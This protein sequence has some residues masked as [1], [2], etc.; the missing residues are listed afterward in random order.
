M[1]YLKAIIFGAIL[2]M[3]SGLQSCQKAPINGD[4]DGLWE[5]ME[6]YPEIAEKDKLV[7]DRIFYAFELHICQIRAYGVFEFYA[8]MRYDGNTLWLDIPGEL[9][10]YQ[11]QLL[12]QVGISENP[13]TFQVEFPDSK[14]LILSND[15]NMIKLRK[16]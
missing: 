9:D 10:S 4:L 16:F 3:M 2:V 5:I 12:R 15:Q 1:K 8:D 7:T 13:V 6:V 14:T 11:L